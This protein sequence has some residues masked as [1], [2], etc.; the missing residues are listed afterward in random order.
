MFSFG[1]LRSHEYLGSSCKGS[2]VNQDLR[3]SVVFS[4]G[5]MAKVPSPFERTG[6]KC[7]LIPLYQSFKCHTLV[8][9]TS[10]ATFAAAWHLDSLMQVFRFLDSVWKCFMFCWLG[11]HSINLWAF[12]WALSWRLQSLLKKGECLAFGGSGTNHWREA[13]W[14]ASMNTGTAFMKSL[15]VG[16]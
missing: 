13:S 7:L 4:W 3:M 12:C 16:R 2:E 10:E 6:V 15:G 14:M 11:L 5:K 8:L 9:V 1:E